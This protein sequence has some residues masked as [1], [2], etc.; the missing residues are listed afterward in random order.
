ME[1]VDVFSAGLGGAEYLL[2]FVSN[3]GYVLRKLFDYFHKATDH[4]QLT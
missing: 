3:N 2:C 4:D 1:A